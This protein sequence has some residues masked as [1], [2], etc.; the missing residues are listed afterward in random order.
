[1]VFPPVC[2]VY[3]FLDL[4][5]VLCLV[6]HHMGVRSWSLFL[7]MIH[8]GALISGPFPPGAFFKRYKFYQC[9]DVLVFPE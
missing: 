9:T 5:V 8:S 7:F 1:M 2:D 6:D 3:R 4:K